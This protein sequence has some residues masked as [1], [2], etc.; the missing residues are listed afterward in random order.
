MKIK[1]E[2][3][4]KFLQVA[5][6]TVTKYKTQK[7]DLINFFYRYFTNDDILEYLEYKEMTKL[8]IIK[9]KDIN[10]LNDINIKGLSFKVVELEQVEKRVF[11]KILKYSFL[12]NKTIKESFSLLIRDTSILKNIKE[13]FIDN[14]DDFLLKSHFLKFKTKFL[15]F[16]DFEI[17]I[18]E[19]NKEYFIKIL[20]KYLKV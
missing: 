12:E 15:K 10:Q 14:S 7:Y 8:E 2:I 5:P 18:F 1:N 17:E 16:D 4:G 11:R 3:L 20:T 13:I 6:Q 19:N 9:N